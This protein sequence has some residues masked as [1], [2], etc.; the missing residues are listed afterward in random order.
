MSW[1]TSLVSTQNLGS[2]WGPGY[3]NRCGLMLKHRK[4]VPAMVTKISGAQAQPKSQPKAQPKT[5]P[6]APG[7]TESPK[8]FS[9]QRGPI[10][11]SAEKPS[12]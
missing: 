7:S 9:L 5:Q 8:R 1:F 6:T 10:P 3:R 4:V 2:F 12:E 11:K